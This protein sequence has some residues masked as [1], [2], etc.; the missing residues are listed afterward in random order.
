MSNE[1][2]TVTPLDGEDGE[3]TGV[4]E[5][6]GNVDERDYETRGQ[7]TVA[8]APGYRFAPSK[9]DLPVITSRGVKMSREDAD[10][11]VEEAKKVSSKIR[12]HIVNE[13]E[14]D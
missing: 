5:Q 8:T 7:T 14:E 11:V 3:V 10:A 13:N 4:A 2:D 12:V 6:F 1:A 9:K